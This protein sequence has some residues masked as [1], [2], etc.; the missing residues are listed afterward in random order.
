M[1]FD[2]Q[3]LVDKE[4]DAITAYVTNQPIQLQLKGVQTKAAPF[5][6]FGVPSYGDL[7][8]T[9]KKFLDGHRDLM[10]QY[11]A[12]LLAGVKANQANPDE[13]VPLLVNDYGKDAE[14][15]EAYSKAGNPAYIGLYESDFTKANGLLSIDPA[16]LQDK[17][18]KGYETA[19]ET[20][21]PDVATFLDATVLADAQKA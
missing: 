3:P 12:A 10:V 19:G 9:S 20:N 1:S 11:L 2:P 6:D 14:V 15:D 5:S 8:F 17:V 13:V 21:L 4:M 18:W 7:L 16:F